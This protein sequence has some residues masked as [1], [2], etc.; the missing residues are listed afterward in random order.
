VPASR[1]SRWPRQLILK[2]LRHLMI[3]M[4]GQTPCPGAVFITHDN[5]QRFS[6]GGAAHERS[7]WAPKL[8][9][10]PVSEKRV[11]LNRSPRRRGYGR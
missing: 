7:R 5:V 8:G 3:K 1:A 11:G 4:T 2:T 10:A 6:L 9:A